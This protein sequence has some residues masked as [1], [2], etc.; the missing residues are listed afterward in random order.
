MASTDE[1][2]DQYP[3]IKSVRT[4][5]RKTLQVEFENGVWKEYDCRPLL[6]KKPFR[7]LQD[8]ALFRCAH[9]D[10]AGYAVVWNDEIDLA[11]SEIWINGMAMS[12]AQAA[13]K[14]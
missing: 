1:A 6:E 14:P 2:T 3:K 9:T 4:G 13:E 10:G 8:D 5:P 7:P 12:P 11:E